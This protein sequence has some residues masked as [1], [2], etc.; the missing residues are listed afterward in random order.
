MAEFGIHT[1][2]QGQ[3]KDL[4]QVYSIESYICRITYEAKNYLDQEVTAGM[5]KLTL[6][7][8]TTV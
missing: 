1:Q 4:I 6:A 5:L 8:A 2:S 7:R 3:P